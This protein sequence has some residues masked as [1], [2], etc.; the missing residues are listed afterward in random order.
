MECKV[1][2]RKLLKSEVM[3]GEDGSDY[4]GQPLCPDHYWEFGG[5]LVRLQYNTPWP[6]PQP[7]PQPN[8]K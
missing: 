4:A 6:Q 1:C 5:G 2:G 8:A 7:E 3:R